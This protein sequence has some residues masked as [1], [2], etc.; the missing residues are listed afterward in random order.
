[1]LYDAED[2]GGNNNNDCLTQATKEY[3]LDS[4]A[5]DLNAKEHTDKDVSDKL[6]KL[7]TKRW[8]EK[9]TADK[10]SEKLKKYSRPGN[11]QNLTVPRVN[12]DIWVNVNHTGKR[13]D[14]RAANTQNIVSKVGSNLAKC[15]DSLLTAR[16]KKQSKEMNLEELI[17]SQTD[18]LALLGHA[19]YELSMKR[20]DAIRTSL[21]K[22][23]TGLCSR[24]VP[25][26]SLL[27]GDDLQQQLNTIKASNKITQASAS[28]TKSQR[29]TYKGASNDNWKRKPSD[30]Y[31]RRSYP[32][33]THWKNRGE[34]SK[35]LRSPLY[36]EKEGCKN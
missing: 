27:F 15:T 10:L 20:R 13:A 31:Y 2:K 5:N 28:G 12:P 25:V 16:T 4:I 29:S 30:Q 23:Y 22:D 19:Q 14:I 36:K 11:L 18:A 26:T 9:L 33:Q 32:L 1:M 21:N 24:N 8:S 3:L 35:N 34:K 17:G 7:V 6:A